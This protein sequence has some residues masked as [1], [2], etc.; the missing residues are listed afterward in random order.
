MPTDGMSAVQRLTELQ[1]GLSTDLTLRNLLGV[2]DAK[3]ELCSRLPVY[4]WEA[5][6]E[7]HGEL[8]NSFLRLADAERVA[9]RR[10][11]DDLRKHLHT[12]LQEEEL[13]R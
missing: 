11:L 10:M 2:L 4:A 13:T 6:N 3:L 7:G 8:A 5:D 12:G 9:C 1:R